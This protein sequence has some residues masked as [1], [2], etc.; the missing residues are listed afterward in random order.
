MD[1]LKLLARQPPK[2][3]FSNLVDSNRIQKRRRPHLSLTID[4]GEFDRLASLDYTRFDDTRANEIMAD[5][6]A[7]NKLPSAQ[8]SLAKEFR[9]A[10]LSTSMR[11]GLKA[12]IN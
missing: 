4:A 3:A 5:K 1:L 11:L 2:S 6:T 7:V 8:E 12:A 9:F 10:D